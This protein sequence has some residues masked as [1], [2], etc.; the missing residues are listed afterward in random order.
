VGD[1][2]RIRDGGMYLRII[3]MSRM[4]G[5][6]GVLGAVFIQH[7]TFIWRQIV[8]VAAGLVLKL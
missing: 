7:A 8:V 1:E 2:H 5:V 4:F 3:R 6:L